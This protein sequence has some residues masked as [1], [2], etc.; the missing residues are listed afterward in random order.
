MTVMRS[1]F[2]VPST[3]EKMM[4]KAATILAD[5]LTLDLEDSVPP[6]RKS[7]GREVVRNYLNTNGGPR[8]RPI[9]TYDSI[10]GKP[11]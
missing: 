9:S 8:C 6:A 2:Y 11:R 10:T 4:S 7:E 5:V 1:V 3:N